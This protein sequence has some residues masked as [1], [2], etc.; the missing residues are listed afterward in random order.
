MEAKGK[1]IFV[2]EDEKDIL[3]L[4]RMKLESAGFVTKGFK[5]ALP[6]LNLLKIEHPDLIILDLMLPDMDGMEVCQKLKSDKATQKIPVLMLTARTDLEDKIQGLEYGADD[7]VTKPFETRELIARI[8][9][10][11]RRSDWESNKNV[12]SVTKDFIIDFNRYEVWVKGKRLDLTL[13]EFK[14]LQLL[15]KRPGWVYN[16]SQILDYL[17]GNDKIVIER[18]IDVHIRNLREKL[19]DYAYLIKNIR[20]VGYQFSDEGENDL[21]KD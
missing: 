6:M 3:E 17:W 11:F 2:V 7:Y 20:G 13:T 15:T 5:T 14:I 12:L 9:A 8:K 4:I 21:K 19:G 10:I 1:K 16:R 18:T